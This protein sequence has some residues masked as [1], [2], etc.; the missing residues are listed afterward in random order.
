[1]TKGY[2][3]LVAQS[4]SLFALNRI[5]LITRPPPPHHHISHLHPLYVVVHT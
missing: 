4:C 1:M 5:G 2:F 3:Q